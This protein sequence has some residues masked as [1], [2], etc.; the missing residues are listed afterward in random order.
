LRIVVPASAARRAAAGLG[1][2]IGN[3]ALIAAN[4]TAAFAGGVA[5]KECVSVDFRF[6]LTRDFH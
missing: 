3:C 6:E 5:S 1:A 4:R 2:V